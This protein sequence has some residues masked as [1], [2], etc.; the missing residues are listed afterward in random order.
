MTD[1]RIRI[2]LDPSQAKR[3]AQEIEVSVNNVGKA[4]DKSQFSM[5]KLAAAISAVITV[6]KVVE[7]ADAWTRVQNQLKQTTD[8]QEELAKSTNRIFQIAVDTRANLEETA[9]VYTKF[10]NAIDETILSD[11]RLFKITETINKS[12][13]ISGATAQESAGA[14]R[15]L[16]Q[17]I[18]SGVLRG[19][20]FNSVSEQAPAIL[21]AVQAETGKTVGELRKLAADGFITSELLVKSLE[22][23]ASTVDN[24]FAKATATFGQKLE[25]ARTQVIAF[26]GANET[27]AGSVDLAGSA[28]VTLSENLEVL[29]NIAGAG[30]ALYVARLIPNVIAYT[31]AVVASTRANVLAKPAVTGL[32][33]ALGVQA[34]ALTAAR[35][36]SNLMT[37]AAGAL[38]GALAFLGGPVG[39]A[40]LAASALVYFGTKAK[41]ALPPI[42]NLERAV[43]ELS[44]AQLELQ[45]IEVNERLADLS[46]KAKDLAVNIERLNE[47][48]DYDQDSDYVKV[49]AQRRV[50]LEKTNEQI[51]ALI[52]R[53]YDLYNAQNLPRAPEKT[54]TGGT[55]LPED[56][57]NY[58]KEI[59]AELAKEAKMFEIFEREKRGAQSV[60][61]ALK[62][63]LQT[64]TQ[65]SEAYTQARL[66]E[67]QGEFEKERALLKAREEEELALI[68]Q[69]EQEDIVRREEQLRQALEHEE[70]MEFQ[71][72][73]IRI[74]YREQELEAEKV[75]EEQ[76]TAIREE[77]VRQR[78]ELDRLEFMARLNS[79]A[80]LGNSLMQLGEGQ[81]K[82]IFKIGQNLA[83]A[84]A[85]VA[86]PVSVL[87][88]FRNGGGYPWGLVP[89]AA[90]LATGLKN[91][92]QIKN[93]KYGGGGGQGASLGGGGS[94]S[95][96]LPT[97]N[98]GSTSQETFQQ[99]R[100]IEIK[101]ISP[102]SLITGEQLKNILETDD[103]VIV[104]LNGAQQDAQ[105]RGVI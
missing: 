91:I 60:T 96:G 3:A 33:A 43:T 54:P 22:N 9:N 17:A 8:S 10:R 104:A 18:A 77:G 29:L 99:K 85:A 39:V 64:R 67:K 73:E 100:V 95:G 74:L 16:S 4:A 55:A 81:S 102:D 62:L 19:E 15:Q 14:L 32:S 93:A 49:I 5:N 58:Q 63:E 46:E 68:Y 47:A 72:E 45:K 92:Q 6:D 98:G 69:R 34:Q 80:T 40:F 1:K 26:V 44:E 7:Y 31:S 56:K 20:E 59:D 87:E 88:S 61:E 53:Q 94:N 79:F 52:K 41:E 97:T 103:N 27:I 84:Q 37:V 30:A 83:L 36:A 57:I 105:R 78:E 50:E 35:V 25:V 101:G 28:I 2:I 13:A 76:R 89:A 82:K 12:L 24:Q 86:L 42:E 66:A 38:R 90:M 21:K 71:K 65:I 23:Y 75:Y 11:E 48:Q 51:K 70:L